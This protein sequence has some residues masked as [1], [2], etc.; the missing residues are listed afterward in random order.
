MRYLRVVQFSIHIAFLLDTRKISTPE[1]LQIHQ[2]CARDVIGDISKCRP[3]KERL[4]I[5]YWIRGDVIPELSVCGVIVTNEK[6][7]EVAG[8]HILQAW[9]CRQLVK[10]YLGLVVCHRGDSGVVPTIDICKE[11]EPPEELEKSVR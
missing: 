10:C 2:I 1:V 4:G 5:P 8:F 3:T 11:V 7:V 9:I 6:F